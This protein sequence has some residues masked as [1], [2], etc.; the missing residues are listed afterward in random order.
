MKTLKHSLALAAAS[1]SA[2]RSP[3]GL[4]NRSTSYRPHSML[5]WNSHRCLSRMERDADRTWFFER[6]GA[7]W[8]TPERGESR[9]VPAA[10]CLALGRSCVHHRASRATGFR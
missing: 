9:A 3:R 6:D 10:P 7:R 2:T 1:L 8:I 5:R 4:A